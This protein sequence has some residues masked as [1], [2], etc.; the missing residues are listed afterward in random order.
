MRILVSM[1]KNKLSAAH[2]TISAAVEDAAVSWA[3][4]DWDSAPQ[5]LLAAVDAGRAVDVDD[6]GGCYWPDDGSDVSQQLRR[7]WAALVSE[8]SEVKATTRGR[9]EYPADVLSEARRIAAAEAAAV[10]ERASAAA[11]LGRIAAGHVGAGQWDDAIDAANRTAAVEREFGDAPAWGKLADAIQRLPEFLAWQTASSDYQ[12]DDR[13]DEEISDYADD[14]AAGKLPVCESLEALINSVGSG[15]LGRTDDNADE[16]DA[17]YVAT[18]AAE[19]REW[20][21]A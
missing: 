6:L 4:L 18:Y 5:T 10:K 9:V 14:L 12:V 16:W 7:D 15:D 20:A 1:D 21:A 2:A 8:V 13:T 3:G 19:L 17:R 11:E